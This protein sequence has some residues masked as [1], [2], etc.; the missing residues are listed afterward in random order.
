MKSHSEPFH[1]RPVRADDATARVPSV[2]KIRCFRITIAPFSKCNVK[3]RMKRNLL[4]CR[5]HLRE[6]EV[7]LEE[8][9]F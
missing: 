6:G 4:R 7:L 1:V 8:P 9:P 2:G 5:W 3:G